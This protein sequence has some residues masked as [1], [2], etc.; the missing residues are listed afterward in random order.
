MVRV[1]RSAPAP[2]ATRRLRGRRA[3]PRQQGRAGVRR[4]NRRA[5]RARKREGS[6]AQLADAPPASRPGSLFVVSTPI[7][8]LGDFT[9]RAVDVLNEV[10]VVL[11]EDTRH[12]RTLLAHYDISTPMQAYHEHNE[13]RATPA[14]VAR[15]Q[16]GD[17]VA[18]VSDAGTPLL[19]D[20]G[21]R[22]VHAVAAAGLRV[23]PVPGPSALLAALVAGA[24]PADRFTFYGFPPR[25]GRE[26]A[27]LMA[28][29]AALPHTAVLYEAPGRIGDT[30]ADLAA[31]AGA[32]R[33]AAVARELTKQFEEV[34][35]G[36]LG[37]LAAY[38]QATAARG[39]IVLLVGGRPAP[40]AADDDILRPRAQALRE[41]GFRPRD[42][43]RMLVDEHG[44]SRNQAYRLAHDVAGPGEPVPV[45]DEK[46]PDA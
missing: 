32:D 35:R 13:A 12:T 43:V 45:E 5:S 28:E 8:N 11:A 40:L 7:G 29:V 26:R 19:S 20:P 16:A 21:G 15:L 4:T 24:L 3:G 37:E 23:V 41:E 9:Q 34:R 2:R 25:K 14:V 22:L 33:P 27:A 6:I 1:A 17:S 39:E 30:L 10:A 38:Y 18:L 46:E 36:T 42:I 31:A 44:A